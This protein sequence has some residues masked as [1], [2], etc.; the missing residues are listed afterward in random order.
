[1]LA[2]CV[3]QP[4]AQQ[5]NLP[6]PV[7]AL[8]AYPPVV[9]VTPKWEREPCESRN[10]PLDWRALN[11]LFGFLE[12]IKTTWLM[13]AFQSDQPGTWSGAWP[14]QRLVLRR[15][16]GGVIAEHVKRFEELARSGDDVEVRG[17]CFSACTLIVTYV[18]KERLCFDEFASLNFHHAGGVEIRLNNAEAVAATRWMFQRYPQSIRDW[19]NARGGVEKVPQ[20][21]WWTLDA[22][23][24]WEMG[25]RKCE[26]EAPPL[27]TTPSR[28]TMPRIRPL[29]N[30]DG[31]EWQ[32]ATQRSREW[33][34]GQ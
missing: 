6:K 27:M 23:D 32:A 15:G 2:L 29:Q 34:K 8:P 4:Q 10:D 30:V 17:P 3:T 18:P 21:G 31:K 26:Y 25:Y 33:I 5:G 28:S 22:S 16:P 11:E 1:L 20:I 9:C 7:Q 14:A 19:L 12:R 24:L 13:T